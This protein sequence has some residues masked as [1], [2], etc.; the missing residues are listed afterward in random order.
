MPC[1]DA[2]CQACPLWTQC[3]TVCLPSTRYGCLPWPDSHANVGHSRCLFIIGEAPGYNEDL[4]GQPWVGKA[5]GLLKKAYIEH[6]KFDKDVDIFLSNAVRCRPLGNKTPNKTQLKACQGFY[7]A[8]IIVLQRHYDEVIVLAVGAPAVMSILGTS[9]KKSFS[10]QGDFTDFRALTASTPKSLIRL[11]DVVGQYLA[12]PV[13]APFPKSCRVF[14]T[15]H[16]VGW[17]RDPNKGPYVR[18]HLSLLRDFLNGQLQ[19]TIEAGTL[20]I[21]TAPVPPSYSISRLSL[22]I[23]SYGILGGNTQTQFHPLKSMLYDGVRKEDLCVTTG[24]TWRNPKGEMEHALFVM[25]NVTHRRRLWSFIRKMREDKSFQLLLGQNIKFDLA[26][27]R[28]AYPECQTWLDYPLPIADLIVT[29]YLHN[30]GR[31]EKSLKA[32]APLLGVTKYPHGFIQHS[33]PHSHSLWQYNVQDTS[34]TL[35]SQEKL[36]QM[37]AEQYGPKSP[38]LS[39]FNRTWYSNLLWL[40]LWME[41]AGIAMDQE[42]LEN[43]LHIYESRLVKLEV[44]IHNRWEIVLRGRGS[45]KSKRRVMEDSIHSLNG[46]HIAIPKLEKTKVRREISFCEE[47]RNALINLL[48][49]HSESYKKLRAITHM[50]AVTG[51]L[52]RYLYPLLVGRGKNHSDPTT[53]LIHSKAF[54]RWYPV[55]SEWKDESSGGTKQAR[56]VAKGPPCQTFPKKIKACVSSRYDYLIWFDYSQLE[57]R[58][59]AILSNDQWM[60]SEYSKPD[61]DFH[62]ATAHRLFPEEKG[63]RFRQVGKTLNF[64]VIY[65][66]GAKQYQTTLMRDEG[67]YR[68]IED[69]QRDIDTWWACAPGLKAW[70]GTLMDFVQR[71]G[72]FE[73]PLI[74]QSRVFL[75]SKRQRQEQI[76]ELVNLPGQATGAN[77]MLSAQFELAKAF[78]ERHMKSVI[79]LNVYDA[80]SIEVPEYELPIVKNLM[81]DCI[82]NPPYYQALCEELGRTL[83]LAYEMKIRLVSA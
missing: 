42:G 35:L 23:E 83:P 33:N 80:A 50:H 26:Y 51:T 77:I 41:E 71:H 22:D 1:R 58:M 60:M 5:G 47:N 52:D 18:A 67:I 54:P 20:D 81:Q 29:N 72:Y 3:I 65:L 53:K 78:K 66:G 62:L 44:G 28:F 31:P 7:L 38:K 46:L 27:L 40:T 63:K 36:E 59:A 6:F 15:Y 45:E 24:L 56:I 34:A 13:S 70:H 32:L 74:G 25:S 14:T 82:P 9:L 73:L 10:R 76:K 4:E 69:C 8:D 30:E 68:S 39:G 64:L 11:G 16:P 17:M 61:C 79:P 21:Q 37:I 55:P 75:G 12:S 48:P 57:L 49:T 2:Q 43:L 19:Y